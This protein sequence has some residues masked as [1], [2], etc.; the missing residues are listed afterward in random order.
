EQKEVIEIF[1]GKSA[2]WNNERQCRETASSFHCIGRDT[3]TDESVTSSM[4]SGEWILAP[5]GPRL[6]DV[7]TLIVKTHVSMGRQDNNM[8]QYKKRISLSIKPH[9]PL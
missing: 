8:Y 7:I 2:A 5:I 9:H 3:K 1:V 6:S 4:D